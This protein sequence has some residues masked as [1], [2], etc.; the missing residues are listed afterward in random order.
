MFFLIE[1]NYIPIISSLPNVALEC[2]NCNS[3]DLNLLTLD[4]IY[5]DGRYGLL[6]CGRCGWLSRYKTTWY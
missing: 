4:K 3:T 5:E 2:Y 6:R 1:E